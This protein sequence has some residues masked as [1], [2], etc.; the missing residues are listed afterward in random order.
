MAAVPDQND[1]PSDLMMPGDLSVDLGDERADRIIGDELPAFRFRRYAGRDA[2]GG[3]DDDG[4]FGNL[5]KLFNEDRPLRLERGDNGAVVDDRAPNVDRGSMPFERIHHCIDGAADTRA[6]APRS[7]KQDAEPSI[8]AR[9][10]AFSVPNGAEGTVEVQHVVPASSPLAAKPNCAVSANLLG[11]KQVLHSEGLA[12]EAAGDFD[13][14]LVEARRPEANDRI[15][16]KAEPLARNS[17]QCIELSVPVFIVEDGHSIAAGLKPA[18]PNGA[19]GADGA[20]FH[21]A[22]I[23]STIGEM[24][25]V[26]GQAEMKDAFLIAEPV[27]P[28]LY[29][30]RGSIAAEKRDNKRKDRK[31]AHRYSRYNLP[32]GSTSRTKCLVLA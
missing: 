11:L 10:S 30:G 22:R 19:F 8:A 23:V 24:G 4:A 31:T 17:D 12:A 9:P 18:E 26:A 32:V 28:H 20:S 21:C 16:R 3:E 6:E 1:M 7:R 2:M 25:R 27:E 13:T 29:V 5:V 14:D 15:A